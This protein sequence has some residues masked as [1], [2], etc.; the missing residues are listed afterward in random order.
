[1][2]NNQ[3]DYLQTS[4][5]FFFFSFIVFFFYQNTNMEF[6]ARNWISIKSFVGIA[7]ELEFSGCNN[8]VP[9]LL[10]YL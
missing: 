7:I 8:T 10:L 3:E 4:G 1:M 6:S 2:V 5:E 9:I